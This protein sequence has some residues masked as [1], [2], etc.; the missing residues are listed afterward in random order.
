[1]LAHG[2]VEAV[3]DGAQGGVRVLGE[4]EGREDAAEDLVGDVVEQLVQRHAPQHVQLAARRIDHHTEQAQLHQQPPRARVAPVQA[5]PIAAVC[6]D[7]P[8]S[9]TPGRVESA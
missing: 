7:P 6:C 2:V 1:M 3:G 8:A 4:G 5:A 9:T